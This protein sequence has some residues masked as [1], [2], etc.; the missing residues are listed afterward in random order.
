MHAS[1]LTK[2]FQLASLNPNGKRRL[3]RWLLKYATAAIG[4]ITAIDLCGSN[5]AEHFPRVETTRDELSGR[6]FLI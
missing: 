4:F 5:L 1:S 2:G 3:M 6:I